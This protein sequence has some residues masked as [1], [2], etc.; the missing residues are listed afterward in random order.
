MCQRKTSVFKDRHLKINTIENVFV[1]G[2][3]VNPESVP[4]IR[5]L[6]NNN[7]RG[8]LTSVRK[9]RRQT[10]HCNP[11]EISFHRAYN[12]FNFLVSLQ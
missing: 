12:I 8:E 5:Q 2:A 4:A 9:N 11:T 10:L 3:L 6:T 1:D 7:M